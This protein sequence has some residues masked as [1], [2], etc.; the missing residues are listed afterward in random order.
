[1]SDK[2]NIWQI[3]P[4]AP[5][6][7]S[8]KE[9]FLKYGVALIWPGDS[10]HWKPGRYEYNYALSDW[11]KWFAE[12]MAEG[13]V[14]LLRT[15]MTKICAL[16]V[17]VG[18][19]SYEDR[20][21]DVFGYD[22]QHCRRV[23]WCRLPEEYDFSESVFTKGRFSKVR[24]ISVQDYVSNFISS[25]PTV[26]KEAPL[27]KLPP[28]ESLLKLVP[29]VLNEIIAQAQDLTSLYHDL[30]G[31]GDL[32]SED[33]LVAHYVVPFLKA[34]GWHTEHIAIQWRYIDI[35]VFNT[36]PRE[37]ENCRFIIEAKRLGAGVE[38]AL[39]QAIKYV[40][41]FNTPRDIIITD[42]IRY[43]V[44]SCNEGFKRVAYANLIRLK[45]SASDLFSR[46]QRP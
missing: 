21:D 44:F 40:E 25:P 20:F 3:S 24:K 23:R 30:E 4:P 36:L 32:P 39:I 9:F 42:G 18:K 8:V 12:T 15:G 31:F 46:L 14:I 19:Y 11:I 45:E 2:F 6:M 26:W 35:A 29:P 7:H 28:E 34:L 17:I 38:E 22:L 10:G 1:M 27:P 16:G 43:R 33:E 13:D 5:V 41:K 37:P